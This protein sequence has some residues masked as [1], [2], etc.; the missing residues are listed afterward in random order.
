[1]EKVYLL[2]HLHTLPQ[3]K[4]DVK[5]I[6]IYKS[7]RDALDAIERV[8]DLPGF[9]DH[10]NLINPDIDEEVDGFYIDEYQINMDHWTSGYITT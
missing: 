2:Q 5:I 4:E 10:P 6:G 9:A 3:D 7:Y 1:M 8:K